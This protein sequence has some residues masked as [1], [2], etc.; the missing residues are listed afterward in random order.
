VAHLLID[1]FIDLG[2]KQLMKYVLRTLGSAVVGTVIT[3]PAAFGAM[4]SVGVYDEQT[5]Q[6][7]EVDF[8]ASY[9]A[10]SSTGVGANP[11]LVFGHDD[12]APKV[13]AAFNAGRG[14]VVQFNNATEI[15]GGSRTNSFTGTFDGGTKSLTATNI[16]TPT[17]GG[18]LRTDFVNAS[19]T[20]ISGLPGGFLAKSDVLGDTTNGG[21]YVFT[22]TET[23]FEPGEHVRAVA[24]T[25]MGRNGS[26]PIG[27]WL[28]QVT[29]DN[30]DI[31]AAL[32]GINSTS[33]NTNSDT[34]YGAYAPAGRYITGVSWTNPNGVFS[35]LDDFAFITST[36]DFVI[37]EP[38]SIIM[39]LGLTLAGANMRRRVC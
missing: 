35:A 33:G 3:L 23:N 19:R 11:N 7:N 32:R 14:G 17:N 38:S 29:L 25:I 34:F 37:P 13:L 8:D 4:V 6:T 5:I 10:A 31:I 16:S 2:S 9:A 24:G 27:N 1:F 12:F 39:A 15:I 36:S 26:A 21:N 20:S 18:H 30:G 22:L 28:M